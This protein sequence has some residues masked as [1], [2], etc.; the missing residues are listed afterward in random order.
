MLPI[1]F[2]SMFLGLLLGMDMALVLLMSPIL[3]IYLSNFFG[4]TS[5]PVEVI[6]QYIFG[7]LDSFGF[8]AIPLFILAGEIMNRGGITDKLV[9]F[10][11]K[12]VGHIR[13]GIGQT[14]VA[15]NVIMAGMSG[16]AVADCASTGSVLIP[17]MRKDGYS[18]ERSSAIIAS[19]STIGP[20]FPPSIPLILI[21][22]IAGISVGKLFLAGIIPG[23]LMGAALMVYI[24]IYAKRKGIPVKE[25]STYRERFKAT[26]SAAL[27]LILPVVIVGSIITGVASPTESA[28]IGVLYAL[29]VTIF[30]YKEMGGKTLYKVLLNS[31]IST[32]AIS[33]VAAGG[34]LFGWVATYYNIDDVIKNVLF[35]ISTNPIVILL[36]VNLI[37]IV[38][39]MVIEAIPI[40]LLT[41][42]IMFPILTSIGVD[43]V[44]FSI[45]MT[46]N[47][48]IGLVT[49]PVGLHLFITASIAR[50]PITSV[51]REVYPFVLVLLIALLIVTFVPATSLFIPGLFE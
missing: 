38:L 49:P 20:V 15:I 31:A 44:H 34:L 4:D 35:S 6:P 32:G 29:V 51:I 50:I 39:G 23:L 14:S 42:P 36:M 17:A 45:I 10:A 3:V 40:I 5:I 12:I 9:E 7:G 19:A 8:T 13:G 41:V 2:A 37:L 1:L 46:V 48:M 24:Y 28:V 22:S 21:G 26:K 30:F 33:I 11:Q 25:K 47:L 16:S 43:P 27:A 18:A